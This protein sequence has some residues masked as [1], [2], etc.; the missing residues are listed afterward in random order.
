MMIVK[1][2][3]DPMP[4]PRPPYGPTFQEQADK[5]QK[6]VKQKQVYETLKTHFPF[7]TER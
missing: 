5:E 2:L 3:P 7:Q 1:V 4:A 6:L